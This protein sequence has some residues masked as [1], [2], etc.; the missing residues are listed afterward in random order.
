[1]KKK[2]KVTELVKLF[3]SKREA[4]YHL[5]VHY[6]TL[7]RWEK[8]DEIPEIYLYMSASLLGYSLNKLKKLLCIS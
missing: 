4:A 7:W 8:K 1:M 3:G 6:I 2:N 5:K